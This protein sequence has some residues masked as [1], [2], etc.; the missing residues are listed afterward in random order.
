[1]HIQNREGTYL[2][3]KPPT[4]VKLGMKMKIPQLWDFARVGYLSVGIRLVFLGF[5]QTDTGG[6]LGRY[7]L[8][9]LF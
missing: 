7:I 4:A 1:M 3:A 2:S 9:L 8:V 6:K 5:Y